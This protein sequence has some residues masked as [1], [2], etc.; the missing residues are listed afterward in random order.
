LLRGFSFSWGLGFG[1]G[2]GFWVL[3]SKGELGFLGLAGSIL[4]MFG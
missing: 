4:M 1:L 2:L 3:T